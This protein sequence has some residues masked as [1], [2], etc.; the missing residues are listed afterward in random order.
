LTEVRTEIGALTGLP[1]RFITAEDM[2]E[3]CQELFYL[4]RVPFDILGRSVVLFFQAILGKMAFP[5]ET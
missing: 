3:R 5:G 4:Q 2:Q 1:V